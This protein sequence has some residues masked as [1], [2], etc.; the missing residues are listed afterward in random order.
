MQKGAG[1][2]MVQ[3]A[4]VS[5]SRD[6]DL[7]Q[8]PIRNFIIVSANRLQDKQQLSSVKRLQSASLVFPVKGQKVII[9]SQPRR[10]SVVLRHQGVQRYV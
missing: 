6:I 7:D 1:L 8:C 2:E 5:N 9:M 4:K 10:A 3:V